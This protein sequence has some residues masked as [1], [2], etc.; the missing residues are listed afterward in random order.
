MLDGYGGMVGLVL[1][2]GATAAARF[3]GRL[4]LVIHAPSLAG[5]ESLISEPRLTS[6]KHMPA[7]E[8]TAMGIPDGFLRLSCGCE[9]ADDI[10]RDLEAALS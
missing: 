8:R 10:I 2:G 7:E 9:D 1:A 5:V 4:K 3:C 6:H